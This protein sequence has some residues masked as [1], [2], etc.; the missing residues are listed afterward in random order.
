[1]AGRPEQFRLCGSREGDEEAGG[2]GG[3]ADDRPVADADR[4]LESEEG[5]HSLHLDLVHETTMQLVLDERQR[6]GDLL[7]VLLTFN[8]SRKKR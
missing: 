2:G 6:V 7:G 4:G 3:R 8:K 5:V 1:M